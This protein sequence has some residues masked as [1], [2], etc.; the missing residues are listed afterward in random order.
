MGGIELERKGDVGARGA[1]VMQACFD[2]GLL[3]RL[4]G[5]TI[6]LS[7]ALIAEP[8]HFERISETIAEVLRG[9]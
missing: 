3:V 8:A 7:P 4:A 6:A 2:R 1:E 9:L 5:D